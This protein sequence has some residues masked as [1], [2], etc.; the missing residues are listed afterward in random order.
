[1]KLTTEKRQLLSLFKYYRSCV[2]AAY[3]EYYAGRSDG[4]CPHGVYVGGCGIDWM[5]GACEGESY[6]FT[7]QAY[8]EATNHI[9]NERRKAFKHAAEQ[10]IDVL[11]DNGEWLNK[12]DRDIFLEFYGKLMQRR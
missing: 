11:A 7:Q 5:C 2:I 4:Y 10:V 3:E 9:N 8:F 1:M 12:A 6:S